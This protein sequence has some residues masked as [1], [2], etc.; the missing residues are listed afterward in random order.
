MSQLRAQLAP[1]SPQLR[2]SSVEGIHEKSAAHFA[3]SDKGRRKASETFAQSA[4]KLNATSQRFHRRNPDAEGG[5]CA[6]RLWC[7]PLVPVRALPAS[8]RASSILPDARPP[9]RFR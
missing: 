4:D 7:F 1:N 6:M 5:A 8:V 9:A 3:R 2:K